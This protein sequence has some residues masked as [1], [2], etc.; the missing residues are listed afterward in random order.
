M[1]ELAIPEGLTPVEG[2]SAIH[3]SL[4]SHTR[5]NLHAFTTIQDQLTTFF[6]PG[7]RNFYLMEAFDVKDSEEVVMRER[8]NGDTDPLRGFLSARLFLDLGREATQGEM[9]FVIADALTDPKYAWKAH[10][11]KMLKELKTIVPLEIVPETTPDEQYSSQ[12]AKFAAA[13][14]LR[15]RSFREIEGDKITRALKYFD[16]GLQSEALGNKNRDHYDDQHLAGLVTSGDVPIRL[17][18]RA[19]TAHLPRYI[20]AHERWSLENF[21]VNFNFDHPD[22]YIRYETRLMWA[23]QQGLQPKHPNLMLGLFSDFIYQMSDQ[24]MSSRNTDTNDTELN[25][26]IRKVEEAATVETLS[27]MM[28][29]AKTGPNVATQILDLLDQAA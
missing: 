7:Y 3:F 10:E 22:R 1:V 6:I 15:L 20:N 24:W 27:M 23:I 25:R 4:G 18:E 13:D 21:A 12:N 8:I 9:D 29:K 5:E 11:F 14:K 16:E 19:G 26:A 28:R 2:Q 17:F